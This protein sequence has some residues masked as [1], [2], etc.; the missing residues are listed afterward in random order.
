[1]QIF[2]K[3]LTGKTITL[4]VEPSDSIEN[5]KAKIQVEES[6]IEYVIFRYPNRCHVLEFCLIIL[7]Q[8]RDSSWPTKADLCWEAAGGRADSLRLQHPEGVHPPPGAQTERWSHRAL[9]P[10]PGPEVQLRQDDLQAVLRQAPPQGHQLQEEVLWS[11][12]Q[13]EAQEEAE[14]DRP[15]CLAQSPHWFLTVT[16]SQD[17][18]IQRDI[19]SDQTSQ[20]YVIQ[21]EAGSSRPSF[22]GQVWCQ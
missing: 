4:E 22:S 9:T 20:R 10:Y 13:P 17:L 5:V 15:V 19:I 2:V 18:V 21:T 14:V 6:I 3:T 8:G 7:G 11:Q 1:M 16:E 12:P